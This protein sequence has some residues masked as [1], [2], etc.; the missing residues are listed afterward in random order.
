VKPLACIWLT[1]A[2]L[3]AAPAIALAQSTA[4]PDAS[5]SAPSVLK[6][7]AEPSAAQRTREAAAAMPGDLRPERK[8]VPQIQVPLGKDPS[9]SEPLPRAPRPARA[10]S[11]GIDDAVAR[12]EAEPDKHVR[13]AC[14]AR[15]AREGRVQR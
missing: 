1:A 8:P 7:N 10:A 13:A 2:W 3:A 12:C 5:A 6:P 15:L 9:A 11:A 14:R 4:A